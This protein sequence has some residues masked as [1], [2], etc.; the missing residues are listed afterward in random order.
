MNNYLVNHPEEVKRHKGWNSVYI[1][2]FEIE[3]YPLC[4]GITYA[5][6]NARCLASTQKKFQINL[7]RLVKKDSMDKQI[8]NTMI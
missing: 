1:E 2:I 3:G 5:K 7:D 4:C 8:I 6:I